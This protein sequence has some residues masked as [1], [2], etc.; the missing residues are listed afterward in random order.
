MI[1]SRNRTMRNT[2]QVQEGSV[3]LCA[4]CTI[5]VISLIG[6]NVLV[7]CSTRYNVTAKQVKA[8][9]EALIAAEA[10]GDVGY[11]ECRKTI[12][13]TNPLAVFAADGWAT[14]PSVR[15]EAYLL[16]SRSIG[17]G[18]I[19]MADGIIGFALLA[20]RDS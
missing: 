7:N 6:A 16:K 5:L 15:T 17:S 9:K 14:L 3:L 19:R 18:S 8:W 10:G 1:K 4:L 2:P 11:A 13:D 20:R 12:G